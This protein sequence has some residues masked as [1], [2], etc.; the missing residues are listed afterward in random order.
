MPLEGTDTRVG[1]KVE[2]GLSVSCLTAGDLPSGPVPPLVSTSDTRPIR[3]PQVRTNLFK[4]AALRF[5]G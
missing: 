3:L 1:R 5:F 4:L 2:W